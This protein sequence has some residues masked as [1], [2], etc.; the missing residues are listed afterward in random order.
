MLDATHIFVLILTL[1]GVGIPLG[2]FAA[3]L[4]ANARHRI[5]A[6]PA[7]TAKPD[8]WFILEIERKSGAGEGGR[9]EIHQQRDTA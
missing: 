1:F 3:R 9:W 2:V 8:R 4:K 7:P 5:A 6:S